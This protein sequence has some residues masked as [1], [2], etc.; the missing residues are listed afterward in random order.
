MRR[1][2][3]L[4]LLI[5][6]PLAYLGCLGLLYA[7]QRSLLYFPQ[8][9]Q[10]PA[11][12]TDF[13][14]RDGGVTLRGWVMNPGRSRALLFFG[15][16][17]DAVQNLRERLAQWAPQ[18]TVYLLAYR[19]YGASEG[20]PSEAALYADALA[21]YDAVRAQHTQIAVLGR[22]LGTGVAIYLA[23]QRPVERLA[24]ITPY[25]SVARVAQQRF[26]MFPVQW[27]IKDKYESWRY[28]PQVHCPV[29]VVEAQAD[30]IIPAR[31]T[32]RLLTTFNPA[33]QLL[34]VQAGHDS[35]MR[36]P[37]AAQ[38]LSAFLD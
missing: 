6:V 4:W 14:L 5:L 18:R 25:D 26:P 7:G 24:L 34:R 3:L 32:E 36:A 10:V 1:K 35:I 13:A 16:N 22:S 12:Q 8:G 20:A 17:G 37:A 21:L 15:G 19:G 28:A 31:S 30:E 2:L 9:T 11:A 27:L 23:A 29:L 38:A 33:P